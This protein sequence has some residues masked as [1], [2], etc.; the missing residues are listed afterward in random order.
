MQQDMTSLNVSGFVLKHITH[1]SHFRV[2]SEPCCLPVPPILSPYILIPHQ[3]KIKRGCHDFGVLVSK[4]MQICCCALWNDYVLWQ[5]IFFFLPAVCHWKRLHTLSLMLLL[6]KEI[7]LIG[8]IL[9]WKGN[10]Y[11]ATV[12]CFFWNSVYK[13]AHLFRCDI[14]K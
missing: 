3:V 6:I 10:E 4:P 9:T 14:P 5:L 13:V 1:F 12:F 11:E 7:F 8:L 2:L